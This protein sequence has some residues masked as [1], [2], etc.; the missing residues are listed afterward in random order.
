MRERI[1]YQL[2]LSSLA[3]DHGA[4]ATGKAVLQAARSE[5]ITL[6]EMLHESVLIR[7]GLADEAER[8]HGAR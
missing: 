1:L 8:F 6:T 2:A 5:N 7:A 4:N 3:N